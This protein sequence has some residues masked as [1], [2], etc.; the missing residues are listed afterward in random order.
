MRY[1]VEVARRG[2]PPFHVIRGGRTTFFRSGGLWY[3]HTAGDRSVEGSSLEARH[4]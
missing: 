3:R 4:G 1:K 2:Q